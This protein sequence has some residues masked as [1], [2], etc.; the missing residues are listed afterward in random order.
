MFPVEQLVYTII[1]KPA[2]FLLFVGLTFTIT[3][4]A[5]MS[6]GGRNRNG[7]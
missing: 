3:G 5:A 2:L 4:I 6:L 1:D 7:R